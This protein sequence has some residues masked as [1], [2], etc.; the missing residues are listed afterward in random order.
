MIPRFDAASGLRRGRFLLRGLEDTDALGAVLARELRGGEIVFLQ[1]GLGAGKTTLVRAYLRHR[2][3]TGPVRSP[4]FALHH[5]YPLE[6][7]VEHLDL[8]RISSP[9]E[10]EGLDLDAIFDGRAIAFVEWPDRLEG[11]W[12]ADWTIA[13]EPAEGEDRVLAIEAR[14]PARPAP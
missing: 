13:L 3:W 11:S 5:G 7:R 9:D 10:A 12:A 14:P 8:Y 1:G 4:S 6:P 2:G